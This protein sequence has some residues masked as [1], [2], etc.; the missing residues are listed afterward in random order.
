VIVVGTH[1][2]PPRRRAPWCQ[3]KNQLQCEAP[4]PQCDLAG[5]RHPLVRALAL[6]GVPRTVAG[7][8]LESPLRPGRPVLTRGVSRRSGSVAC[9]RADASPNEVLR[10][11]VN[12]AA[13]ETVKRRASDSA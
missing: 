10:Y 5:S 9:V 12:A 4:A 1:H 2:S 13:K 3:T 7:S 8:H 6:H 11:Q